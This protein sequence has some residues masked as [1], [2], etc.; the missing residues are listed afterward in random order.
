MISTVY[1]VFDLKAKSSQ[2]IEV[3]GYGQEVINFLRKQHS[4]LTRFI[5]VGLRING[6]FFKFKKRRRLND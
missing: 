2:E 6:K 1:R 4:D 5:F 3:E